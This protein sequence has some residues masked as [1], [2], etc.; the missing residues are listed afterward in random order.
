MY[1]NIAEELIK[2]KGLLQKQ[3]SIISLQQGPTAQCFNKLA[4]PLAKQNTLL[5]SE[6]GL[7]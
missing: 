4:I 7:R 1:S 3:T 2:S 5:T 6:Q